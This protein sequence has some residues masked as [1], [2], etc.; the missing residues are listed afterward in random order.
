MVKTSKFNTGDYLDSPEATADYARES[1]IGDNN[2]PDMTA[3][4][5]ETTADISAWMAEHPVITT[6]ADARAAKVFI[7][8]GV[9]CGRDLEDERSNQ[10]RPLNEKVKTIN[11]H[12]RGPRELLDKVLGVLRS[13]MGSYLAE[14]ERRRFE[15]AEQ[16]RRVAEEA[17]RLA[18]DAEARE[19]SQIENAVCGELGVDIA[20]ATADADAR[21]AEY[22]KAD[23]QAALAE[24]ETKVRIGG[25]FNRS[26]S[27]KTKETMVVVDYV[28]AIAD[29]GIGNEIIDEAIIKAARAYK[30]VFG[31]YP[32][33]IRIETE[34]KV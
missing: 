23:R 9:L 17:E 16:A 13:R 11:D 28:A 32:A 24:R 4:A 30:K 2:P 26:I 7:D 12:Y 15:V 33:G 1:K 21:F 25:G 8:R 10:V 22:Q 5:S 31:K 6:E 27:L 29:I 19:K 14:E 3:T 20:T 18:R 34:R